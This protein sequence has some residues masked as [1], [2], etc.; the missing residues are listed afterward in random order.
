MCNQVDF[1]RIQSKVQD[2][3]VTGKVFTAFDVT[4]ALRDEFTDF[5][6]RHRGVRNVVRK[7]SRD[8]VMVGYEV[9]PT[10]ITA[11][12]A[13]SQVLVFHPQGAAATDHPL[14]V[15]VDP[16]NVTQA[17]T[18]RSVSASDDETD[19]GVA[20]TKEKRI[21]IPKFVLSQVPGDSVL[22]SING[23][24]FTYNKNKDGR[25][26]VNLSHIGQV[27]PTYSVKYDAAQNAVVIA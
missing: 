8:G 7:M 16:L 23:Q 25:V 24:N 22:V 9:T 15:K 11:N 6:E 26:R 17:V 18:V 21:Q 10:D 19:D 3:V 27:K 1:D 12:G 4:K 2:F 14:A 20:L 13:I 5:E